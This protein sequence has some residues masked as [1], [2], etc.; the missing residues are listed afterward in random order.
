MQSSYGQYGSNQPASHQQQQQHVGGGGNGGGGGGG[1][2]MTPVHQQ[3][4]QAAATFSSDAIS[5]IYA[6]LE[7]M[8]KTQTDLITYLHAELDRR[9]EWEDRMLKDVQNR[10]GV[11]VSL[12]SNMIGFPPPPPPP[13]PQQAA[14]ATATGGPQQHHGGSGAA[15]APNALAG[16]HHHSQQHGAG[17]GDPAAAAA[18]AAAGITAP[19]GGGSSN[20]MQNGG[21]GSGGLYMGGGR[22]QQQ[23]PAMNAYANHHHH[24]HPSSRGEPQHMGMNGGGGKGTPSRISIS[25]HQQQPLGGMNRASM[26]GGGFHGLVDATSA[27]GAAAAGGEG[28]GGAASSKTKRKRRGSDA[29]SDDG[30]NKAV[31][32]DERGVVYMASG[33][34]AGLKPTKIQVR[35]AAREPFYISRAGRK[36]GQLG[37]LI[38]KSAL[39]ARVSHRHSSAKRSGHRWVLKQ[40]VWL[41]LQATSMGWHHRMVQGI[42]SLEICD[43]NGVSAPPVTKGC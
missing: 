9:R 35:A 23:Q 12:L 40:E 17:G 4:Q 43:S 20:G 3:Q 31:E 37:M 32:V 28:G 7:A 30:A 2:Q 16:G 24:H 38:L 29:S 36:M 42:G 18:A 8:T 11:L 22:H 19:T 27:L 6:R 13:P 14:T 10:H 21:G 5:S 39:I 25:G 34:K 41:I 26:D 15:A 1:G 33:K